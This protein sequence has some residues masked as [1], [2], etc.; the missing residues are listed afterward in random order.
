MESSPA[1]GY[2]GSGVPIEPSDQPPIRWPHSGLEKRRRG[3]NVRSK[4]VDVQSD[5][6]NRFVILIVNG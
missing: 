5:Y 2:I 1:V 3:D 6:T 4:V